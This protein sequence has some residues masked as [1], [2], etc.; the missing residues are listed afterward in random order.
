MQTHVLS[1]NYIVARRI[2]EGLEDI[3]KRHEYGPYSSVAEALA[4]FEKRAAKVAKR[5]KRGAS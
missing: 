1:R 5:A 4:A 3:K 2:V